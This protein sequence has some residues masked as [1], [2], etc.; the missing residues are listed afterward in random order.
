LY[1]GANETRFT[2]DMQDVLAWLEGG[3]EPRT[4]RDA[5]FA[6]TRLLTLQTRNS[7]AYKGLMALLMQAGGNDLLNGDA[8]EL[9]TYFDMAVDIHHIFPK[10]YCEHRG[11]APQ[12]WN[13][14]INKAPLSA[15]TNRI[16]GGKP[17]SDY[18]R[19]LETTHKI[20]PDRL[21]QILRSHLIEP[22]LMRVDDFDGFLR[23]RAR[24]LL[25][26]IEDATGKPIPGR[27]SEEVIRAFGGSLGRI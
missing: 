13:S 7:A 23:D 4:I 18:L 21:D 16:I 24:R 17:P 27:D 22:G 8:I 15:R 10:A 12:R 14:V 19:R 20:A 11:Y 26:L 5:N 2:N 3:N 6:P 9:T 1:G 25:D